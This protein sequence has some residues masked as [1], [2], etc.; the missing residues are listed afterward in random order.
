METRPPQTPPGPYADGPVAASAGADPGPGQRAPAGPTAHLAGEA[1]RLSVLELVRDL[2]ALDGAEPGGGTGSEER[3]DKGG[4]GGGG[5]VGGTV[6]ESE[7]DV[8]AAER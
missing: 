8:R 1:A 2:V 5:A 6:S 7:T 3:G 4:G